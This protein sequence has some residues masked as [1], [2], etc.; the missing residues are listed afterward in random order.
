LYLDFVFFL[1]TPTDEL[2]RFQIHV[3]EIINRVLAFFVVHFKSKRQ[4]PEAVDERHNADK[5]YKAH[6]GDP[7]RAAADCKHRTGYESQSDKDE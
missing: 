6:I 7:F 5:T 2:S 3:D 1:S 4:R